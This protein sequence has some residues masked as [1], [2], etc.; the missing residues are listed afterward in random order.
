MGT[1]L[2]LGSLSG[3]TSSPFIKTTIK[4]RDKF[5]HLYIGG[6]SFGGEICKA[7]IDNL[8]IRNK[9]KQP[10]TIFGQQRD[11]DYTSNLTAALPVVPDVYT[12]YLSDFETVVQK[13]EDFTILRNAKTGI[14]DFDLKIIDSFDVISSNTR[15]KD[16]LE[17]MVSKLKPAVSRAFITYVK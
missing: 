10:I 4:L 13:V 8:R 11:N 6:D 1:P 5:N 2:T 12:T 15:V 14:F 3:Y 7:R 16:L 9:K 17:S